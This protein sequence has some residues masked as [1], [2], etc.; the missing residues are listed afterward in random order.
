[1]KELFMKIIKFFSIMVFCTISSAQNNMVTIP[2]PELQQLAAAFSMIVNDSSI[3]STKEQLIYSAIKGMVQLRDPD[4]E[5]FTPDEFSRFRG[6]NTKLGKA[7]VG[8]ELTKRYGKIVVINPIRLAPAEIAGIKTGDIIEK[9]NGKPATDITLNDAVDLL[10]GE[11]D[12]Q[13]DLEIQRG[14]NQFKKFSILRKVFNN[15][16]VQLDLADKDIAILK[17]KTLSEDTLDKVY[18]VLTES[19]SKNKFKVLTLDLRNSSGGTLQA[20]MQLASIFLK[21]DQVILHSIGKINEANF[22]YRSGSNIFKKIDDKF[23]SSL[24]LKDIPLSIIINE[25]TAAGSEIIAASLKENGR[26][27]LLG[28][29][30]FGKGTIQTI[31]Q[32]GPNTALRITTSSWKSPLGNEINLNGVKPDEVIPKNDY[33][34]ETEQAIKVAKKVYLGL[35]IKAHAIVIGNSNYSG[36]FRLKNATNDSDEIAAKLKILG[37]EVT[38]IN[39]ASR[40][41]LVNELNDFKISSSKSDL[42]LLFYA[43]HGIQISGTNY[44]IPVNTNLSNISQLSLQGISISSIIEQYMP[45]RTKLVFL[46]ACRDNPFASVSI[47]STSRSINNS[48]SLKGLAQ[49]N[50]S[51][52]TLISYSTKDNELAAD[53]DGK[54]SPYTT[55]L[56]EHISDPDDIAVVLRKVREK[57]MKTTGNKQQPW[58]Y[59]SLTGGALVLSAIKQK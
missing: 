10:Y 32:L 12:S 43:G 41:N 26:A 24:P 53:G 11:I 42:T 36:E 9:I 44:I 27:L 33:E 25:G 52:G 29:T 58:E 50:V 18:Q 40:E 51:E 48:V 2:L 14:D 34:T 39:N 31:R 5:Y 54:N 13:V 30:S 17:I 8:L 56:L 57:V 37:F 6:R 45:G 1:M 38:K 28:R 35:Q 23:N 59:G 16:D 46:D 49:I 4:G 55:A 19:Y 20:C 7:S 47:K 21:N 22:T 15:Q 3:P